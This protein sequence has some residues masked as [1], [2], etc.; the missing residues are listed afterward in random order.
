MRR[1]I[2]QE[3]ITIDGFAAGENDEL[4]FMPNQFSSTSKNSIENHQLQF[5]QTIDTMLLGLKTYRMFEAY[6]PNSGDAIAGGLNALNKY[7]FS[8]TLDQAPWGNSQKAAIINT[9]AEKKI[10]ALKGKPG[11][12]IVIWGSLSLVQS[13]FNTDVIDEYQF[14]LCPTILG[15]GRKLFTDDSKLMNMHLMESKAFDDSCVF[16]RYCR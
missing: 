10:A 6:W 1:V 13:L 3:W 5:I 4:D 15:K 7:V 11:K 16:L 14:F 9:G 2:V 8:E 12:D